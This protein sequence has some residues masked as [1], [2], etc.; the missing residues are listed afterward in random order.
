[1][2]EKWSRAALSNGLLDYLTLHN[3]LSNC[4]NPR[5]KISRLI[6]RRR[7]ISGKKGTLCSYTP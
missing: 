3:S 2:K 7:D 5:D 1:M 4:A 6:K